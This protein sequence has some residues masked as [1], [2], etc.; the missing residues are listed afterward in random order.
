MSENS[1]FKVGITL[2]MEEKKG[3]Q[4]VRY[5]AKVYDVTEKEVF[6]SP[7][8]NTENS[9][10][11]V[12]MDGERFVCYF[13]ATDMLYYNFSTVITKT[14]HSPMRMLAFSVPKRSELNKIQRREYVRVDTRV[15]AMVTIADQPF[16]DEHMVTLDLSGG[17]CSFVLPKGKHYFPGTIF[18]CYFALPF[19]KGMDFMPIKASLIRTDYS[20]TPARLCCTFEGLSDKERNH[21]IQFVFEQQVELRN[22]ANSLSDL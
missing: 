2:F 17:G 12:T 21:I 13:V 7:L 18:D 8:V 5:R 1:L 11:T 16:L 22:Q 10:E 6:T 4:L 14:I 15:N 20:T 3:S 9:R 19:Q